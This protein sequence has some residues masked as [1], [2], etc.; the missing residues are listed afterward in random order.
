MQKFQSARCKK[1]CAADGPSRCQRVR[2]LVERGGSRM[3]FGRRA[4][5]GFEVVG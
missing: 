1:A 3:V 5:F 2:L 4:N